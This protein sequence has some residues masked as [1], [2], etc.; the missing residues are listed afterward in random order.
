MERGN[1][2]EW[3]RIP[4]T[5]LASSKKGEAGLNGGSNLCCD[6]LMASWIHGED[7]PD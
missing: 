6:P 2:A 7:K 1:A 5:N 4:N 3:K